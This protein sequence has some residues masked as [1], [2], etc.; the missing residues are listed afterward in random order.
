MITCVVGYTGGKTANPTYKSIQ[1]YTEALWIEFDPEIVTY[2]ELLQHWVRMH[3][4]TKEEKMKSSC[5]YRAGVWYLNEKQRTQA[6][7]FYDQLKERTGRKVTSALEP[8]TTFYRAEEYH[9][10]FITNQRW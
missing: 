4:P 1:D 6:Q 9:Q 5:Q 2:E 8:V 3:N 10:N 7:V